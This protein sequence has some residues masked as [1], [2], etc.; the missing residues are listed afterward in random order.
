MSPPWYEF[1]AV[2]IGGDTAWKL[3]PEARRIVR[4]CKEHGHGARQ[5]AAPAALRRVHASTRLMA[6]TGP[7]WRDTYLDGGLRFLTACPRHPPPAPADTRLAA[8]ARRSL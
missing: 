5:H 7:K 4:I 3:G 8:R 2:F 6:P 1:D